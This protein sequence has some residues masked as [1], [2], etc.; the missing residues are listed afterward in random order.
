MSTQRTSITALGGIE[1]HTASLDA[2]SAVALEFATFW[3]GRYV[4]LRPAPTVVIRLA[5]QLLAGHLST[6]DELGINAECRAFMD[7][8]KGRGTA[9]TLTHARA[10]IEDHLEAPARQPMAHWHDALHSKEERADTRRMLD[11]MERHMEAS[12]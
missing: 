1:K 12:A 6:L 2:Q 8:G 4:A 7:A 5:L 3:A 10:R 9:R 11:A